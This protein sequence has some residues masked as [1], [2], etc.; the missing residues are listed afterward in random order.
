[1]YLKE[2]TMTQSIDYDVLKKSG[3]L[4]QKQDGFFVLRTRMTAGVYKKKHLEKLSEISEK[5]GR[6]FVHATTRQGLEVPF[7]KLEDIVNVEKEL[8]AAGICR[9]ASG[10]RLRTTTSCPGNNWC[11]QGLV[12]TFA[13]AARIEDE[14]GVRC[15]MDLPHK[16]KIAI[17][18]C[19]NACTRPQSS[20]IGIHG[21]LDLST[22]DK[23][24]GFV[25][26][27]G[28][29]GGRMPRDGFR[30]NKVFSEDEVLSITEK[31]V[32]FFKKNASPRQRLAMLIEEVGREKFLENIFGQE[33]P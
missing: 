1:M 25:V 7:I 30:I 11:K 6:G 12:N 8:E 20:E 19:P 29:C 2:K 15:A 23:R 4:R 10:P 22:P 26:Y 9:G 5:Y 24:A 17:S 31:V 27:L 14:L 3:F 21:Q 13:L 28:G 16:F 32:T 33:K 18:G